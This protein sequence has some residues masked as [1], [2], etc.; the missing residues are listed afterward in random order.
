MPS[1]EKGLGTSLA[2]ETDNPYGDTDVAGVHPGEI[3][4][5]GK[6]RSGPSSGGRN[7]T[8]SDRRGI[9]RAVTSETNRRSD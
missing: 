7:E 8:P 6:R 1:H 9:D 3:G 2:V 5:Y 4:R